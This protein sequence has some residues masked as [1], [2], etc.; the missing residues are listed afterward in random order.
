[1]SGGTDLVY[2]Y[3]ILSTFGIR[4]SFGGLSD[5]D[6]N[7]L[8][9]ARGRRPFNLRRT[10]RLPAFIAFADEKNPKTIYEIDP[11][12]LGEHFLGVRFTALEIEITSE[13]ITKR[14]RERLPWL[15]APKQVFDR[16]PPGELTLESKLPIGYLTTRADFFG[17][18][19]R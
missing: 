16:D 12:K 18:G 7:V 14:L 4:N 3:A 19:S 2:E 17:D 6:F 9:T 1:M 13:P 8:R 11:W 5:A 15:N 10:S